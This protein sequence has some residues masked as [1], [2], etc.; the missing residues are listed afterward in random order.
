MCFLP[1]NSEICIQEVPLL[2]YQAGTKKRKLFAKFSLPFFFSPQKSK[3]IYKKNILI[4]FCCAYYSWIN[5]WIRF[6]GQFQIYLKSHRLVF[7]NRHYSS[8]MDITIFLKL[9]HSIK[10]KAVSVNSSIG[11]SNFFFAKIGV[12]T[13]KISEIK[14]THISVGCRTG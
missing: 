1:S 5:F 7:L 4:E 3:W 9:K 12:G 6:L 11:K 14:C 2:D 10:V 8:T 13:M